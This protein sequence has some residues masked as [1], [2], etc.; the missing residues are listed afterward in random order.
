MTA[1]QP[2]ATEIRRALG[3]MSSGECRWIGQPRV[4]VYCRA[5]M[6]TVT[7]PATGRQGWMPGSRTWRVVCP[8]FCDPTPE[9]WSNA[10]GAGAH[11]GEADAV[12]MVIAAMAA[13]PI[14]P[15]GTAR[16]G[17]GPMAIANQPTISIQRDMPTANQPTQ[18]RLF[19]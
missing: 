15:G 17:A 9:E 19:A 12:R 18:R 1:N 10:T 5:P 2:T 7:C 16:R 14:P 13:P 4:H 8:G 11:L 3:R 6:V